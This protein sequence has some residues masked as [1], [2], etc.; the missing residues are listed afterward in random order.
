MKRIHLQH[1]LRGLIVILLLVAVWALKHELGGVHYHETIAYLHSIPATH[2]LLALIFTICSFLMLT[3]YDFLAVRYAGGSLPK[4]KIALTSY[5]AYAF[6]NSVGLYSLSG[7][8]IRLRMYSSWGFSTVDVI[9]IIA[10]TSLTLWV[11]LLFIAG[12]VFVV[13]P[14]QI[15]GIMHLPL[16]GTTTYLGVIL[17]AVYLVF[18]AFTIFRKQAFKIKGWEF[19]LPSWRFIPFMSLIVSADFLFA[20]LTCF[21]LLPP[22]HGLT[23]IAFFGYYLLAN[24]LGIVSQVPGGIGIFE[25][26]MLG[27]MPETIP[28][29][30][31][32]GSLLAFRFI[33]YVIP[34]LSATF[35]MAAY[36][37]VLR[38]SR[39]QKIATTTLSWLPTIVPR[40][41]MVATFLAGTILLLSGATP[42]EAGRLK[43][44]EDLLPLSVV[45]LSHFL[46]SLIG[47]CLLF[48]ARGFQRR[49]DSAYYLTAAL[50]AV[51]AVV[52]LL[53]GFDYEEATVLLLMLLA[54][55]PCR[56]YFYRKSS[57]TSELVTFPWMLAV[58]LTLLASVL[59]TL[60]AFQHMDYSKELW[61]RFEFD[62]DAPRSLRAAV[63]TAIL[64]LS[65]GLFRLFRPAKP[66]FKP[67]SAEALEKV[68]EIVAKSRDSSAY[69][70]LL[71]DKKFLF[72][73]TGN[74]FI[75]YAV[76][77]DS[78]IAMGDPVGDPKERSDLIWQF[79]NRC[80]LNGDIPAFYDISPDYLELYL[81]QGFTLLKMGE[82][83]RVPLP[84]FELAGK[85]FRTIRHILN[86]YEREGIQFEIIPAASIGPILPDLRRISDDW[87]SHK[88]TREKGFSLGFFSDEYLKEC[89]VAIARK[90]DRVFAFT[91]LWMAADKEEFAPDLMRYDASAPEG[92]MD[93]IFSKLMLWGKEEGFTWF[94][95]GMAPLVGLENKPLYP[96]WHRIGGLLFQFGENFY[97]FQGLRAYKDKFNPV[98]RS[99][100]LATPFGLALPKV[101]FNLTTLISGG[102][103]GIL[104]K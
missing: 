95:L 68:P 41:L 14:E 48:L 31:I 75:M 21:I 81:D 67:N 59:V 36:E 72:S 61:W 71:G 94:S 56:R 8:A 97:N 57:L 65:F 77:G 40:F 86:L 102:V 47:V 90:E 88:Q 18:V 32:L 49:L 17:L 53:K 82:E 76:E 70:A 103:R 64:A 29:A 27:L 9:R 30:H 34:L 7:S 11:G 3:G 91:N 37:V 28:S 20:A 62:S 66:Q 19:Q 43:M 15:P 44:L 52:S 46:A 16:S 1:L 63:G 23:F 84:N 25:A 39:L 33:Y 104:F 85:S 42:G 69:L 83:A 80:H 101:L 5:L 98:W 38:L 12:V 51:G 89:P 4:S 93:F 96:L 24:T 78:W 35:M 6:S 55:L 58:M 73:D 74:S 50:L 92:V 100:F 10:F 79:R 54:L 22:A 99:R 26:T 60:F 13:F 45:E 87:L 2:I